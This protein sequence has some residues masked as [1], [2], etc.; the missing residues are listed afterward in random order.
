VKFRT[1][2]FALVATVAVALPPVA[3]A[4][5][6]VTIRRTEHGIPHVIAGDWGDLAYGYGYALAEDNVCTLADTYTTVRAERSKYFGPDEGYVFQG[7]GFSVNNLNSDFFFQRII[8]DQVVEDLI[9]QAPP[10]G[11]AP[12]IREAVAGYVEGYNRY[13]RDT[14]V[15]NI[16]DARCAGEP[17]V[18][19]IDEIDAYRRFYQLA[20]LASSG[21]AIDGIGSA[22]PP[23]SPGGV[24]PDPVDLAQALEDAG[25]GSPVG[26]IGSNAVGLGSEGTENGSGMLLGNPHFP[27][28]GSERFYQAQLTIPGTFNASGASLFGVPVILIGHTDNMAW[29]HTVSTA[30]R[31][32]P[33]EETLNPADPTQYLYDGSYLDMETDDVTV[34]S[35]DPG[36]D[37]DGC[38]PAGGG[39]L[40][41]QRTLY[42]THHG[43]VFN[44]LVGVPLPWTNAKAFA[45]GDANAANF[46]YL[47]HFFETNQAQSVE[48]L[49]DVLHRNQ[50][51]PWVNTI[52][53]DSSGEAYYADISVTPHVTDEQA[54][55]CNTAAGAA[56][57][58]ALRLPILDGSR[59]DCEWESDADSIQPGTFGPSHMPSLF[60]DDYVTNSNDS[61]WLSNPEQPLEGFDKII[62]DERTQRSLRT[63]SGLVMVEEQLANGGSFSVQDL[64]DTVFANR[65]YAG[66]LFRDD[67]VEMCESAPGG[68]LLDD[69]ATPV[70]VSG[71][72]PVLAD[73]DLHDNLDSNGAIL[74]RRF[75]SRALSFDVGGQTNVPVLPPP[76]VFSNGFNASDPVH[77]PNGL[78]TANPDV[79]EALAG[80]VRDLNDCG[81]PLDA[82][83]EGYQSE[84]RSGEAIPIHGGPGTLGVFN[85]INV[86]WRGC[87]AYNDVSHGSSFVMVTGFDGDNCLVDRSILTYSLSE[88]PDSPY[89]AD[90]TELFSGKQWVDVPYYEPEIAADQISSRSLNGGYT[91]PD[92]G[93]LPDCVGSDDPG[94]GAAPVS[95]SDC[96]ISGTPGRDKIVGTPNPDV[97]CAGEGKDRVRGAGGNDVIRGAKGRDRLSG[98]DGKDSIYGEDGPDVLRGGPG[99]DLLF[100][101]PG[102]DQRFP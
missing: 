2:A 77:T 47:N 10:N 38:T 26:A 67:L 70:D 87:S 23:T 86:S 101:G 17:W 64:Q 61:Y 34:T 27:W 40:T 29:S 62:G 52:A 11:P 15:A 81:I 99:K 69:T 13:I 90:Q 75:E 32:T 79:R 19:E 30:Y 59:T 102:R 82:P 80:A 49:D 89:Y 97:I 25:L 44:N 43:P 28:Q 65:Q 3:S 53:A 33:F 1:G 5:Y 100:G 21:V 60:R 18:H 42:S 46:R 96:T 35:Q 84:A 7:N 56:A 51:I 93:G 95:G 45:M 63:R 55:D 76:A 85:A 16:P 83:L 68:F 12:A 91:P 36:A 78:N 66:E 24:L 20:L 88:N 57:F 22:Q 48:E 9:A 6:E 50:G 39:E 4:E 98:N 73:W 94:A 58:Q 31:F 72:C 92:G 54:Q 41:C 14:G 8:D 74:F 37:P 71:A